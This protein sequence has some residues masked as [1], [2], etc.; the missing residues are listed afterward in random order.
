[1]CKRW[2]LCSTAPTPPHLTTN[3]DSRVQVLVGLAHALLV[4]N[5]VPIVVEDEFLNISSACV[6][7]LCHCYAL[8][9]CVCVRL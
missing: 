6:C 8:S 5:I 4:A 7:V 3:G 1:M 2:L 9:F